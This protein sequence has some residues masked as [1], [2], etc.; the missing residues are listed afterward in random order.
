MG[1]HPDS[2][3]YRFPAPAR[4]TIF[5]HA[6]GWGGCW[7]I[8]WL[9]TCYG[10][11]TD[12]AHQKLLK[13][14]NEELALEVDENILDDV[15]VY[16]YNDD[17]HR[18]FEVIPERLFQETLEDFDATNTPDEQRK[19]LIR[20]AQRNFDFDATADMDTF[21]QATVRLHYDSVVNYLFVAD[22]VALTTG[23][24]LIVFFDDCGRTV[25]QSRML[26][27]HCDGTAGAWADC[28]IDECSEFEDAN[29]GPGYLPGG[30]CGPRYAM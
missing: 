14:L 4:F 20:E 22:R 25:R 9:R 1:A 15:A 27:E 24:V 26:P 17:W 18:I 12:E 11:G 23:E 29:I 6:R 13:N 8:I 30:S 19:A 7:G 16:D 3:A 2:S 28:F 5:L 21:R 10:K